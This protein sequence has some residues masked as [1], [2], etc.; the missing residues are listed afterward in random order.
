MHRVAVALALLFSTYSCGEAQ[1]PLLRPVPKD[2]S[3][4]AGPSKAQLAKQA[5]SEADAEHKDALMRA[6]HAMKKLEDFI[7]DL[8]EDRDLKSFV[9]GLEQTV[10]ISDNGQDAEKAFHGRVSALSHAS[11]GT[12]LDGLENEARQAA[13]DV[14]QAKRRK[15]HEM[16]SLVSQMRRD[17]KAEAR[18]LSRAA[19]KAALAAKKAARA[20]EQAQRHAG[21]KE[22]DYEREFE[23]NEHFVED[24]KDHAESLGEKAEDRIEAFFER[25]E[26]MVDQRTDS[27]TEEAER[28]L[29]PMRQAVGQARAEAEAAIK[30]AEQSAQVEAKQA[31]A[32]DKAAKKSDAPATEDEAKQASSDDHAAETSDDSDKADGATQSDS[33]GQETKK[34][35]D[36]AKDSDDAKQA[37][38]ADLASPAKDDDAA[39]AITLAAAGAPAT[40]TPFLGLCGLIAFFTGMVLLVSLRSRRDIREHPL[41]G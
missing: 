37:D 3:G 15:A 38:P 8:S 5:E 33:N 23:H 36:S 10:E 18:D 41:L 26:K 40:G 34:R 6:D 1:E 2:G 16:R 20:L 22:A 21:A 35:D 27:I 9:A 4:E 30:R 17:K 24:M 13:K 7:A 32:S 29:G 12:S 31:D 25:V 19:Q 28:Q 39:S 14:Q 11:S